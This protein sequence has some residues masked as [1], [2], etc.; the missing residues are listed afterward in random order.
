MFAF[1]SNYMALSCIV[2]VIKRY[3]GRESRFIHIPC[4]RRPPPHN[5]PLGGPCRNIAIMF[6]TWKLDW[7]GYLMVK[8]FR[9]VPRCRQNTGVCQ[10]DG[11]TDRRTAVDRHLATALFALCLRVA[12][13]KL[14]SL[15]KKN[16]KT[17]QEM[18]SILAEHNAF[19]IVLLNHL[20]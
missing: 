12:R 20:C 3:V 15:N 14:T 11:R 6:G 9:I 8:V 18:L 4:I 7:W 19:Q 2:V 1:H 10:T 17:W 5:P 16:W 13:W